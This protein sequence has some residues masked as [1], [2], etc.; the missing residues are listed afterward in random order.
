MNVGFKYSVIFLMGL[1]GEAFGGG[2][3]AEAL[4]WGSKHVEMTPYNV[5]FGWSYTFYTNFPQRF[6]SS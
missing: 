3:V 2:S 4:V 6:Y 5:T 1:G